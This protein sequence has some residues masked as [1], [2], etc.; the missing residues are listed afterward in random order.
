MEVVVHAEA[1]Q[2]FRLRLFEASTVCDMTS[3]WEEA[4]QR[5][6]AMSV[7]FLQ[8]Q[9]Y[10]RVLEAISNPNTTRPVQSNAML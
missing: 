10:S 1:G 3:Q 9:P 2:T 4:S 7:I 6:A 5:Q 8:L